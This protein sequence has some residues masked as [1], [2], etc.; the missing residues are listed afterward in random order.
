LVQNRLVSYSEPYVLQSVS[1][2]SGDHY[3]AMPIVERGSVDFG[4]PLELALRFDGADRRFVL[5]SRSVAPAD[6]PAWRQLRF[7]R[8]D[9]GRA[10][11]AVGGALIE[12]T[13]SQDGTS[14]RLR[15][16]GEF[17]EGAD[18]VPRPADDLL[19]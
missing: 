14:A 12:V 19:Q 11:I 6:A 17:Q 9:D 8:T 4:A 15:R 2:G 10:L 18:A 7:R 13:P 3:I 16:L 1:V 5:L